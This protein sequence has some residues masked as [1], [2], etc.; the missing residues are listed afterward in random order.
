MPSSGV[1]LL[2]V[3]SFIANDLESRNGTVG[4][5]QRWDL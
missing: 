1:M 5:Y 4:A 2:Q 3:A